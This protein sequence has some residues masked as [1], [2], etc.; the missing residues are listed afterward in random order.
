MGDALAEHVGVDVGVGV[1]V[2]QR[3]RAVPGLHRAQDR[4]RDGVVAAQRERDAAGADD[5]LVVALDD[6][7]RLLRRLWGVSSFLLLCFLF[8]VSFAAYCTLSSIC[9]KRFG[10][11]RAFCF[12]VVLLLSRFYFI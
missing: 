1:H 9:V 10:L 2:D 7:D 12:Y 3:D 8:Q 5:G 11:V 4:Q 6:L